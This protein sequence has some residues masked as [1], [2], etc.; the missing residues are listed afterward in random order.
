MCKQF[1]EWQCNTPA[2]DYSDPECFV[3]NDKGRRSTPRM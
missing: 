1:S 2:L 3:Y